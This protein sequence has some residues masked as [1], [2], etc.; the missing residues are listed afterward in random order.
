MGFSERSQTV[1]VWWAIVF[2]AI[3]GVVLGFL[4]HMIPPPDATNS[5]QEIARWYQTHA[6]EIKIGATIGAYSGAFL[7]PLWAVITIQVARQEAGRPIWALMAA[8]GG[9]LMSIFLALPPLFFGVAAFTANRPPE[10]TALMHELGVLTL[11][12]TDQFYIFAWAAVAVVCL[13]PQHAPHSPFPRW[14]GYFTIWTALMFE[15]GAVAFNTRTGPF[16]WNGLLVFWSPLTLFGLW[17][18]VMCVLLLRSLKLQRLDAIAESA[19]PAHTT[20]EPA[21]T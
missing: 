18:A 3:Y 15:A 20:L 12:T 11:V 9:G 21:A 14:F 1:I 19:S 6:T 7:V 17:I 10:V 8:L 2:T 13:R 5:A 16:S 4:L